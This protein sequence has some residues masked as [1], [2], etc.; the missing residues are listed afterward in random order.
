MP[1]VAVVKPETYT[2]TAGLVVGGS[3][4][5][6]VGE[7]FDDDFEH[8]AM[9]LSTITARAGRFLILIEIDKV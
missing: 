1:L 6:G 5:I 3:D 2:S 9:A 8:D 4:V 7:L